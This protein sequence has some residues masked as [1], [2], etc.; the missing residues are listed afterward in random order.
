MKD[1]L[2]RYYHFF[3]NPHYFLLWVLGKLNQQTYPSRM[4][5]LGKDVFSSLQLINYQKLRIDL[6][7]N[8]YKTGRAPRYKTIAPFIKRPDVLPLI[9]QQTSIEAFTRE[10]QCVK[11]LLMDSYSELVDQQFIHRKEGW[12][13]CANYSDLKHSLEFDETFIS[14]GLLSTKLIKEKY[15]EFFN[16]IWKLNSSI[17][18]IFI[19]F[20]TL[21]DDRALFQERGEAIFSAISEINDVRLVNLKLSDEKVAPN[22]Q[23][24]FPYHFSQQTIAE[25]QSIVRRRTDII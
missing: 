17:V 23:A 22:L 5:C 25:I 8:I 12:S 16:V 14:N 19:H 4:A 15:V 2:Y 13:F 3:L 20:P 7:L 1:L 9:A 10:I 21:L 6:F 24:P 11:H 18:I